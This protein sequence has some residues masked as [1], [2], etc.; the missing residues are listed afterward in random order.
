MGQVF[1][2]EH[3]PVMSDR[4]LIQA[5]VEVMMAFAATENIAKTNR[6]ADRGSQ[7]VHEMRARDRVRPM[8]QE[9]AQHPHEAVRSW[10]A[11]GLKWLDDPPPPYHRQFL[12][13][14]S[15]FGKWIICLLPQ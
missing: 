11:L 13:V 3:L 12:S 4:E 15:L 5:Y 6:L 8:L 1:N 10:A 2:P 7:I 14:P 9:L